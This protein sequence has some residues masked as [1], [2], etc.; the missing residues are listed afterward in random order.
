M[1]ID[2]WCALH[3]TVDSSGEVSASSASLLDLA[4]ARLL[5]VVLPV[6]C[7]LTSPSRSTGTFTYKCLGVLVV[8]VVY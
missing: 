3:T 1:C 2:C 5:V 6:T 4:L 7:A 8:M